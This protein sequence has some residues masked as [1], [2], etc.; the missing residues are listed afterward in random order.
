MSCH[1]V[2]ES[3]YFFC[4]LSMSGGVTKTF[5]LEKTSKNLNS[6]GFQLIYMNT[7][8]VCFNTMGQSTIP[9]M[10]LYYPPQ[11]SEQ[12]R[13]WYKPTWCRPVLGS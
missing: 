4:R 5:K 11:Q 3:G 10:L 6:C 12:H 2:D 13:S 1:E 7:P 9:E 8:L